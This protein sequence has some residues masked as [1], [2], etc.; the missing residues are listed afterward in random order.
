[1][2]S[3]QE[4]KGWEERYRICE[5]NC[6]IK[7]HRARERVEKAERGRELDRE[8]VEELT[9]KGRHYFRFITEVG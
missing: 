3:E 2:A 7:I 4:V 1:M 5:R 9:Q 6:N 8:A